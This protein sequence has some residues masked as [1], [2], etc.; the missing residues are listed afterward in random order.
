M[1]DSGCRAPALEIAIHL[2][3]RGIGLLGDFPLRDVRSSGRF[4]AQ[5]GARGVKLIQ[6]LVADVEAVKRVG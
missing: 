1:T 3:Y 2:G 5:S 6:D 4:I